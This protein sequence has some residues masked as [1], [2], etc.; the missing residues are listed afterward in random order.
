MRHCKRMIDNKPLVVA[1]GLGVDSTAMLVGFVQRGIRPDLILFADTGAEKPETMAYLEVIN[2]YLRRHEFPEVIVVKYQ[3]VRATYDNLYD[4]CIQNKT[5][6]SLAF[7]Y[8]KCSLKMKVAPQDK[9]CDRWAPAQECWARG[10]KVIKAI[11]YDAGPKDSRRAVDKAQDDEYTYWYP[12][13][14]WGWEREECR[15]QILA[16][17]LPLPLKSACFF[18]PASQPVE[19]IWLAYKH[20]HLFRRAIELEDNARP[21]F[22]TVEGLW[23]SSTKTRPGSWRKFAEQKGLITAR[24][25]GGFDLVPLNPA[26][27]PIHP[28]ELASVQTLCMAA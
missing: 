22:T 25:D 15:R 18:C 21:N 11:G 19:V 3:P 23:R 28:D 16:A 6:P 20:P 9:Y 1:Y 2:E 14:D 7:G 26:D 27:C 17:G 5:L 24:E 4:N 12:L 10:E 13:R 8:K